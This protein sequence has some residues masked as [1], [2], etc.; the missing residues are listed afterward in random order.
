MDKPALIGSFRTLLRERL[1]SI[2]ASIADTRAGMRVDGCFRPENR[3]ERAAVTTQGYLAAGLG[4][5]AGEIKAALELLDQVDPGPRD[6]VSP[7]ALV[8]LDDGERERWAILLPGGQG[9]RIQGEAGPVMV[10]SPSSPLAK[11][12]RG[13]E[14]GDEAQLRL[15]G[16]DAK[17][18]ILEIR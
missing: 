5:R 6:A 13:R 16:R 15:E 18:E 17:V 7:G 1:S 3:G 4:R 10:V 12:L 2:E 8:L 9:D 11:A 14:E